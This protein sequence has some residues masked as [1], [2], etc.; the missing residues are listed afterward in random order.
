[1]S[2]SKY[3]VVNPDDICDNYGADTLRMYE[4]FLGPIDQAKPW[5]TSGISGV[6]SFLKKLWRL[7]YNNGVWIV[8]DSNPSK[9]MLKVLHLTIKKV[10]EDIESFSFNTC[11]SSLMICVNELQNLKCKSRKVL[12]KLIILLSPFAPHISEEIWQK[13]GNS[14]SISEVN[15]PLYDKKHLI[16]NKKNYPISFNGKLKFNLNLSL[17]LS[18]KEIEEIVLSDLRTV[19][20]LELKKVKNV[21]I[22]PNKII[23]IVF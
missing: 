20:F 14:S 3:N 11:I 13:L 23:N 6:H 8:D 10:S 4:M 9:K 1:M 15:Y 18:K 19:K 17:D 7:F 12:D 5:N 22:V 2:K 21:I 16:E